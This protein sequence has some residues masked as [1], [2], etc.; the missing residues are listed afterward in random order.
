MNK[1]LI[2]LLFLSLLGQVW[3]SKAQGIEF[4][5]ISL[6]DALQMAAKEEKLV[7]IDFYTEWCAPCKVMTKNIFPLESVGN[8]FNKNFISIKLDAEKEGKGAAGKYNISAYPTFLFLNPKGDVV[9]LDTGSKPES[10]FI[11][12][13]EKV[14]ASLHDKYSLEKLNSMYAEKSEDESFLKIYIKK[15]KEY[16]QSPTEAIE[17]WLKYQTEFP[18][19]HVR[20]MEFYL[21][22]I[23]YMEV[24]GMAAKIF[25]N[26][27]AEYMDIATRMEAQR[28]EKFKLHMLANTRENAIRNNDVS[29]M[30]LFLDAYKALPI[31]MKTSGREPFYEMEYY[32]MKKDSKTYSALAE[33][34]MESR[35]NAKSIAEIKKE[36]LETYEKK[37]SAYEGMPSYYSAGILTKLKQGVQATEMIEN[38]AKVGSG[39][40]VLNEGRKEFRTLDKWIEYGY[41]LIPDSYILDNLKAKLLMKQGK[42]EKAIA[43]KEK[44]LENWPDSDKKKVSIAYELKTMKNQTI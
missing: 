34:F 30:K 20:M 26:N 14:I 24:G 2:I 3:N 4:E 12:L 44:A 28:I 40:L 21:E 10:D 13:G 18:N 7:F 38:I 17:Q 1:R 8:Y 27:R 37:R 31:A 19:D 43:L 6:E 5:H 32:Q 15:L 9:Y 36:D 29:K 42:T 22:N 35:M 11:E 39:Y 16:G 23:T 41:E 33:T 25:A